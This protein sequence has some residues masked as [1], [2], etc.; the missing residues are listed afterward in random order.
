MY[1]LSKYNQIG[2]SSRYRL[3]Q[4][5]PFLKKYNIESNSFF[6]E[7]YK[8]GYS[9]KNLKGLSYLIKI[10]LKRFKLL[11]KI[12]FK[13]QPV[14]L[15][16]EFLPFIPQFFL[17]KLLNIKYVVDYD[18]AVFHD[19]DQHSSSLIRSLLGNKIKFV[20][21]NAKHVITGS[22]YLTEYA[23]KFN[24]NVTEIPTSINIEKYKLKDYNITNPEYTIGWIGS[25]TTSKNVLLL[26]PVFEKLIEL[27]YKIKLAFIGFDEDLKSKFTHLPVE[28]IKWSSDTEVKNIR[29]FDIGIMPLEENLFNKGKCAFKLIQY[30]ACGIPTISSDFAANR[31]VDRNNQNLFAYTNIEWLD[32]FKQSITNQDQ[33]NKIGLNNRII[34]E[35]D[36]SIQSNLKYYEAI[37]DKLKA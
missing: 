11:L 21:K 32:A 8:P 13:N 12:S 37:F 29:T 28:F 31:K 33:F 24:S 35:Q 10:Y 1:F 14:F 3:Y 23:T 22:P 17:F 15:Q 7:N 19:Y 26:I 16:Y 5:I 18:D 30:M 6:D 2:P 20:I 36:Y 9:Y 34:I 27:D 25:K 4:Y